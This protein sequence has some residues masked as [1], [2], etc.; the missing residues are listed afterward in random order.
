MAQEARCDLEK[1]LILQLTQCPTIP[2][3]VSTIEA[4]AGGK[5]IVTHGLSSS[6]LTV[7]LR[8]AGMLMIAETISLGI[9]SLPKALSTLGLIPGLILLVGLG[10]LA[11]YTGFVIGQ[12]KLLHPEVHSMGDAGYILFG[13][14]GRELLGAGQLIFIIFIMGSHILTFSIMMNAITSHATCTIIFML[15]GMVISIL[16]TLPRTLRGLTWLCVASFISIIAA[17]GTTMIGVSITQPGRLHNGQHG[18]AGYLSPDLW[19]QANLGFHEAFLAVANIVFAY[20]GHVAFFSFISEFRRPRD[21]PKALAL[22]QCSDISLYIVSSVVI[23]YYAGRQV[24]SPALDSAS[25]VVRKIAYGL[26][27]PTMVIAGVVNGHVAVKYV[28]VR[29]LRPGGWLAAW[30]G[31]RKGAST[32][33]QPEAGHN[34]NAEDEKPS[35]FTE[36][37]ESDL[38]HSK[39]AAAWSI[40]IAIVTVL[41]VVAWLIS[42]GVPVF[43][44]LLGLTSALFASWFTYGL[45]GMFWCHMNLERQGWRVGWKDQDQDQDDHD[46]EQ[47]DNRR[48]K[49]RAAE[50]WKRWCLLLVNLLCVAVGAVICGAGLYSSGKSIAGHAGE[51]R[52]FSCADNS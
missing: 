44:D 10:A 6:P 52:S 24:A 41:W 7:F 3:E 34:G 19:P 40:W 11:S 47:D 27:I 42:E 28:F 38:L 17:V 33:R 45:S 21:F 31:R 12:F 29:L 37:S 18:G 9:L 15:I 25:P 14:F 51:G 16:F 49:K 46:H 36:P 43:N 23:Y 35:A 50:G 20:A 13:R 5:Q 2:R 4:C 1:L 48:R 32:Q 8:Q 39:G 26:A 30:S 22:L